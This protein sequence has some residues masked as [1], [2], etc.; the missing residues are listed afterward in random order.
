MTSP[1]FDQDLCLSQSV[2]DLPIQELITHRAIKALA[3]AI[4]PWAAR[5]DVERLHPDLC[6]PAF[7]GGGN[8]LGAIVRPYVRWRAV[9]DE[10]IS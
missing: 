10:Q 5:C 1:G 8:E 9:D 4:L 6:Q 7:H 2:K 3:V